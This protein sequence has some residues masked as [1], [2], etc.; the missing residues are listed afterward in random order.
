MIINACQSRVEHLEINLKKPPQSSSGEIS[1][2]GLR[3][4]S[5]GDHN[6]FFYAS[7]REKHETLFSNLKAGM[8]RGCAALYI[9]DR[10]NSAQIRAE[11]Q[12]FGL[13]LD[14]PTRLKIV[15][16][17]EW[18]TPDGEFQADRVIKQFR[19]L[20]DENIGKGFKGLYVSSDAADI[21]DHLSINITPWLKYESSLGR[22]F[23]FPMEAICAY[24]IDQTKSN[25]QALLQLVGAH[26]NII[27]S[28]SAN[29]LDCKELC[30]EAITETLNELLGKDT[31]KV[32][33]YHLEKKFK[34]SQNQIPDRIATLDNA[35]ENIFGSA[36]SLIKQAISRNLTRKIEV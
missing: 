31:S 1:T 14:N 13:D 33:L 10:E 16:S 24:N 4:A 27:T 17:T 18:Y 12:N 9:A 2:K 15:S 3:D 5:L 23:E 21:F 7:S 32:I 34:I 11:M 35:L 25:N 30:I 29:F 28:K 36:T 20:T 26:K 6:V 22:T 19:T 8:H